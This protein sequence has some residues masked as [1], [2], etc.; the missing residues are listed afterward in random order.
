MNNYNQY[1]VI[2][3]LPSKNNLHFIHQYYNFLTGRELISLQILKV[4]L[5]YMLI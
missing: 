1:I 2:S 3:I 5:N 4:V